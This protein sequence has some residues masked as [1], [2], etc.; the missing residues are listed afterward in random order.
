MIYLLS[1]CQ[2]SFSRSSVLV[3]KYLNWVNTWITVLQQEHHVTHAGVQ[4]WIVHTC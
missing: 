2:C 3:Q 1:R 4:T